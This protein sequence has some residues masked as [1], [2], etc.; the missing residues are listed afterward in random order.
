MAQVLAAWLA[1]VQAAKTCRRFQPQVRLE[2]DQ[3]MAPKQQ[4]AAVQLEFLTLV[5][6]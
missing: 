2:Q 3:L 6:E 4:V 5:Q 1:A